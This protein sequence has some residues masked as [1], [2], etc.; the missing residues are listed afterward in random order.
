MTKCHYN[1]L[2]SV[3]LRTANQTTVEYKK[4]IK[5]R[6]DKYFCHTFC[7]HHSLLEC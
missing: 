7:L 5:E 1:N 3:I 2:K 4:K 6:R